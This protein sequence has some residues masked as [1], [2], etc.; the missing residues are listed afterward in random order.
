MGAILGLDNKPIREMV[1]PKCGAGPERRTPSGGFGEP[2]L[3]CLCGYEF[4]ELK[5]LIIAP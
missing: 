4:Q 3:V 1:C 2:H 5:C